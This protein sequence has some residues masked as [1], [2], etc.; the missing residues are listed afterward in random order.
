MRARAADRYAPAG[1]SRPISVPRQGPR[2]LIPSPDGCTGQIKQ[3]RSPLGRR[4]RRHTRLLIAADAPLTGVAIAETV[5]VNP[6]RAS[7]VLKQLAETDSIRSTARGYVG[8]PARLLDLYPRRARPLVLQPDS[9]W[10]AQ[11]HLLHLGTGD[12]SRHRTKV[13]H[14]VRVI[15]LRPPDA[16]WTRM[17]GARRRRF[18]RQVPCVRG[19]TS[20]LRPRR[21]RQQRCR[22]SIG[23]H[24][25]PSRPARCR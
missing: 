6:P 8:R 25:R 7:Q 1:M 17:S 18:N 20:R 19:S 23:Q 24:H 5:G 4:H 22:A 10:V 11:R 9:Y 15:N 21:S 16:S 14:T 12:H 2:R 3:G 13:T